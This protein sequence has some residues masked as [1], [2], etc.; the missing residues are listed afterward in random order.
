MEIILLLLLAV[1]V[2]I[3][4][5]LFRIAT[6]LGRSV[7]ASETAIQC[8]DAHEML[9]KSANEENSHQGIAIEDI[10]RLIADKS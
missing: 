10:K 4:A 2:L 1:L 8:L 9:L 3:A 6:L 7:S 5:Q